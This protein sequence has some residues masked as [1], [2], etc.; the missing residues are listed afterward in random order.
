[1]SRRKFMNQLVTLD[2]NGYVVRGRV[3][4]IEF[5]GG[6]GPVFLVATLRGNKFWLTREELREVEI[7]G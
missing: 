2:F 7:A 6:L 1:M 3:I 5:E 4:D